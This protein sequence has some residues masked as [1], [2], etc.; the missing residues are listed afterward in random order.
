M[1]TQTT[2]KGVWLRS[3][4]L[5][6]LLAITLYGFSD[7]VVIEKTSDKELTTNLATSNDT[8]TAL[9]E[10]ASKEQIEEYNALAKKYNNMPKDNVHIEKSDIKR[11]KYLYNLMT[12]TQRNKAEKFPDIP[13]PPAPL[14]APKAPRASKPEMPAPPPPLDK[15][16]TQKQIKVYKDAQEKHQIA[17]EAIKMKLQK[18]Q[19]K[20]AKLAYKEAQMVS[21]NLKMRLLKEQLREEKL[22]NRNNQMTTERLKRNKEREKMQKEKMTYRENQIA[23]KLLKHKAEKEKLAKVK[24]KL[25]EIDKKK[26]Q[27]EKEAYR[28]NLEKARHLK[29]KADKNRSK[30]IKED[31]RTPRTPETASID[32]REQLLRLKREYPGKEPNKIALYSSLNEIEEVKLREVAEV[33]LKEI[34]EVK[35]REVVE[36]PFEE[37]EVREIPPPPPPKSPIEHIKEMA[38]KGSEFYFD[39]KSVSSKKAI[40]LIRSNKDLNILTNHTDDSNFIVNLSTKPIV[41][42]N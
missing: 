20:H 32:E 31:E 1:K 42:G 21:K 24:R 34:E 11:L 37:I 33:P 2:K 6:P 10:K 25:S 8:E 19:L 40:N 16:A 12:D 26:L 3:L 9:Q 38:E 28:K 29:K 7:K 18:Q 35:V 5:L 14:V 13:A 41:I 4:I 23:S 15:N 30:K 27:L 22:A 39:G 17:A 36:V